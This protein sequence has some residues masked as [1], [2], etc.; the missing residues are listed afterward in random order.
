MQ[1]LVGSARLRISYLDSPHSRQTSRWIGLTPLVR[2]EGR[3]RLGAVRTLLVV[4]AGTE[5]WTAVWT[6]DTRVRPRQDSAS[7]PVLPFAAVQ[8]GRVGALYT[9]SSG[10]AVGILVAGRI[11]PF[12]AGVVHV[13]W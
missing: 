7:R 9:L 3:R 6:L 12:V 8:A 5:R 13:C 2:R 10:A 11:L 1:T 4:C